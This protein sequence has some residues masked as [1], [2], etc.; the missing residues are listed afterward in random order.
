[1]STL[2]FA[3]FSPDNP[4]PFISLRGSKELQGHPTRAKPL[5]N[6]FIR[7]A[8]KLKI[9]KRPNQAAEHSA[10]RKTKNS[11]SA[12]TP[13]APFNCSNLGLIRSA[14]TSQACQPRSNT[15][16]ALR[17]PQPISQILSK[18][19]NQVRS[20]LLRYSSTL[21]SFSRLCNTVQTKRKQPPKPANRS[22]LAP[23]L[24]LPASTALTCD[25]LRI[26]PHPQSRNNQSDTPPAG[27]TS[28][29]F[30]GAALLQR[31]RTTIAFAAAYP[32]IDSCHEVRKL[33]HRLDDR[34]PSGRR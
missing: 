4:N 20:S 30:T 34:W 13:Q 24:Y 16:T 8:Q 31:R 18:P 7:T 33:P 10:P 28:R 5:I 17:H 29:D 15:W 1:M 23:A 6:R 12:R 11:P 9:T 32:V 26:A 3:F 21:A 2:R 22:R 14:Q 19:I 27:D 25:F